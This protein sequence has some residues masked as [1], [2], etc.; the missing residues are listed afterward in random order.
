MKNVKRNKG[1]TLIALVITI[2]VLLILAAV[3]LN[4]IMGE[5][6]IFS[7]AN[8]AKERTNY[9]QA[10][11]DI[12]LSILETQTRT[13]TEENRKA[14]LKD[15]VE[16]LQ[17]DTR[18]E[19]DVFLQSQQVASLGSQTNI[20]DF[21]ESTKVMYV[22][23]HAFN[24]VEIKV[25]MDADG[26]ISSSIVG[27]DSDE[28]NSSNSYH[29]GDEVTVDGEGFYVIEES[30]ENADTVTLIT[31]NN[32]SLDTT[33]QVANDDPTVMSCTF[34]DSIYWKEKFNNGPTETVSGNVYVDI[35]DVTGYSDNDTLG[36]AKN[37]VANFT[38]LKNASQ[39]RLLTKKEAQSLVDNYPQIVRGEFGNA[40]YWL[41]T[42]VDQSGGNLVDA[43]IQ[44]CTITPQNTSS[45]IVTTMPYNLSSP[46]GVRPVITISKENVKKVKS[47]EFGKIDDKKNRN[48]SDE[49]TG[50]TYK[51]PVIPKGFRTV[52][53]GDAIWEYSD[54]KN[55][56]EVSGW[57][58]GL[59]IEDVYNG[60]QFV[61]VP[62]TLDG[63]DKTIKY[64]KVFPINASNLG[65]ENNADD[66]V[67]NPNAIPV[68]DE[69]EQIRKYQGYYIA[70]YEA[71]YDKGNNSTDNDI[72]TVAPISKKNRK[73]W[74]Y[75][76]CEN[77]YKAAKLMVN[78]N[79]KY[80][81]N[82]SGIITGTQ[83]DVV[84]VFHNGPL[85][86]DNGTYL[87]YNYELD[88]GYYFTR[89]ASSISSWTLGRKSHESDNTTV[90][91]FHASGLN[92]NN[93][94]NN[95]YDLS[96]NFS[97]F[98]SEVNYDE[99]SEILGYI[100]RGAAA[101]NKQSG[102]SDGVAG[103]AQRTRFVPFEYKLNGTTVE[104]VYNNK[105][106]YNTSFR[107]VLYIE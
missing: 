84:M 100:S 4:L 97:E 49:E 93:I 89:S 105:G 14:N 31:K 74:N 13:R 22:I 43:A 61:W 67:D 72:G 87:N 3:V 55:K 54:S 104:K 24:N 95:I 25:E 16:T 63:V 19:Y 68:S 80:G 91:L 48:L 28:D 56:T 94:R 88:M 45:A 57:H 82:K 76:N 83:W 10:K 106:L 81:N 85:P 73:V 42:S 18:Y 62:C 34:S 37:Y 102:D 33:T 11:E 7:K 79:E 23:H 8:R 70:R 39:V 12:D 69:K 51:N 50:Y 17:S 46:N 86:L 107:C 40:Y 60:N 29:I 6:G 65:D 64:E 96:G 36:R 58:K 1:I 2:I 41:G 44:I 77:A 15:V 30:D 21:T 101:N 9:S 35:N 99:S 66:T 90:S 52:N 20:S 38:N 98:T 78:D 47:F 53:V 75:I 59:V 32:I 103:I 92:P 71:G 26:N 5:N 27:Q